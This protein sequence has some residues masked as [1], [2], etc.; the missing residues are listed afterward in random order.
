MIHEVT[1]YLYDLFRNEGKLS[2]VPRRLLVCEFLFSAG[3]LLLI[4]SQFTGLYYS[5]DK[6]NTYYR[7]PGNII[8]FLLPGIIALLQLSAVL[9]R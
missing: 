2:E 6:T 5:F 8:S 4:V 3:V 1:L 7:G 9:F